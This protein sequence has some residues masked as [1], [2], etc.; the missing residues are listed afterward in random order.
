MRRFEL[1][2]LRDISGRSGIGVVAKG[3]A[4]FSAM[5]SPGQHTEEMVVLN[6]IKAPQSVS[7]WKSMDEL[8]TIHGHEGNTVVHWVDDEHEFEKHPQWY[9]TRISASDD[10]PDH[11]PDKR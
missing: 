11:D 5:G 1:R 4:F 7:L 9:D 8:L 6:W 3:V 2:R 10:D